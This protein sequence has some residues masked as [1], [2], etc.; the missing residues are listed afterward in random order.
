MTDDH[1]LAPEGVTVENSRYLEKGHVQNV[2]RG[3]PLEDDLLLADPIIR[4]SRLIDV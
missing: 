3:A 1:P 2:R 4:D